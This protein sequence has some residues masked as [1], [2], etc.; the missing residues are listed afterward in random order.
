MT[1][2]KIPVAVRN[3]VWYK[4]IGGL[5]YS[6]CF[7][8]NFEPITKSNYECGHIVSEKNGGK[9]HLNN[10]RPICSA[11]NKSIGTRNME[12]FMEQYGFEKNKNWYGINKKKVNNNIKKKYTSTDSHEI[13]VEIESDEN[14]SDEINPDENIFDEINYDKN[15]SDEIHSDENISDENILDEINSDEINSDEIDSDPIEKIKSKLLIDNTHSNK[16]NNKNR[17]KHKFVNGFKK[18]TH[19]DKT[20]RGNRCTLHKKNKIK[21][22]KEYYQE[23]KKE[24]ILI[25]IKKHVNINMYKAQKKANIVGDHVEVIDVMITKKKE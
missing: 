12:H 3:G 19:C 6:T 1:K 18:G 21:R 24:V 22:R 4:Y 14:I 8:C 10:L 23:K 25:P 15:I 17:C 20:C 11:C 7:C 9:V 5:Y 13:S 2:E 16:I